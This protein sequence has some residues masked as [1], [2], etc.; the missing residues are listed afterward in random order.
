MLAEWMVGRGVVFNRG[1]QVRM[2]FEGGPGHEHLFAGF[3]NQ[4]EGAHVE[5]PDWPNFLDFVP[6][7]K[8]QPFMQMNSKRADAHGSP[9]QLL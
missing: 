7:N 8:G 9:G 1:L 4:P 2:S 5:N 6:K 3:P